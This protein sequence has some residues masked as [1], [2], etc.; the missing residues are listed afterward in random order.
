METK[1]QITLLHSVSLKSLITKF[2]RIIINNELTHTTLITLS[3][4][5]V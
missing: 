1:Y 4:E 5:M 2:D 3:I